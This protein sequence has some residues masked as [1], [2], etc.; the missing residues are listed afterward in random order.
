MALKEISLEKI[1]SLGFRAMDT[2]TDQITSQ[3]KFLR[4]YSNALERSNL[5]ILNPQLFKA[6]LF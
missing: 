1:V 2:T 5:F 6:L 3:K 4:H